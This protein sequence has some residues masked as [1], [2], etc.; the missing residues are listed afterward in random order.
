[1]DEILLERYQI[2]C[3]STLSAIKRAATMLEAAIS[4]PDLET[5]LR[6]AVEA[7]R[8]LAEA[9]EMLREVPNAQG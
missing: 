6:L 7:R 2:R 3:S 1:M 9:Q 8:S 5:L 4:V